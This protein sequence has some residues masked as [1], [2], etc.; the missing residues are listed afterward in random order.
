[1]TYTA[2]IV[3]QQDQKIVNYYIL[4]ILLISKKKQYLKK[5]KIIKN[6][7]YTEYFRKKGKIF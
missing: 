4:N 5:I 3:N 1:M 7:I 6:D 2:I